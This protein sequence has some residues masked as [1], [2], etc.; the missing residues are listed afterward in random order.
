MKKSKEKKALKDWRHRV[1]CALERVHN[2][3]GDRIGEADQN[4]LAGVFAVEENALQ[5]CEQGEV[6][7]AISL[8][9]EQEGAMVPVAISIL[10]H[11]LIS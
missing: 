10:Q 1:A 6:G 3:F 8:L 11:L 9:K 5:L 4:T 7:K 2:C